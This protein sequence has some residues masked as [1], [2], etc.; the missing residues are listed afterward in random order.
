MNLATEVHSFFPLPDLETELTN[1]PDICR[2]SSIRHSFNRFNLLS[3]TN[4]HYITITVTIIT[5]HK[6][7]H[8]TAFF[9]I[10][11]LAFFFLQNVHSYSSPY[12]SSTNTTTSTTNATT[13]S[14]ESFHS[15]VFLYIIFLA[16]SFSKMS[17]FLLCKS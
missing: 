1:S 13:T 12:S 8:P 7:F 9:Y 11:S 3:G 5:S 6:S 14:Y 15:T 16:F 17:S 4:F 2:I 10:I